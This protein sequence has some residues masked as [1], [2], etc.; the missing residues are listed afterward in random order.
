MRRPLKHRLGDCRLN[1]VTDEAAMLGRD[2][3]YVIEEAVKGGVDLVQLR[4]KNMT[5]EVFIARAMRLQ[6]LLDRY[7]VPLVIND[8]LEVARACGAAA[9][10]V[11][12]NDLS[13]HD[14]RRICRD[15]LMIGLSVENMSQLGSP[16][17]VA[18]DYLAASPVFSTGTKTDT[19]AALG[20]EGLRKLRGLS[21]KPL[22]AIGGI[23]E[24]NAAAVVR[25]GAD[26]IAVVSAICSAEQPA[27]AAERLRNIIEINRIS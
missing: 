18:A 26:C 13:P 11:G 3:F 27:R 7:D 17:E 20:L 25:A 21:A 1:L 8:N 9:V 12:V 24:V 2:F 6:D 23:D 14:I 5:T 16:G 4:E 15:D 22:F 10:H 19:A